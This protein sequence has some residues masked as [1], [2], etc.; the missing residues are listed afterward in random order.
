M[1]IKVKEE[2]PTK[3][4]SP[5]GSSPS[6]PTR[7]RGLVEGRIGAYVAPSKTPGGGLGII[8]R[9]GQGNKGGGWVCADREMGWGPETTR[10]N[11]LR[12]S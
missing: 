7:Q 1:P 5:T 2:C 3:V 10:V 4:N 8:G 9:N 12:E 11:E 6:K